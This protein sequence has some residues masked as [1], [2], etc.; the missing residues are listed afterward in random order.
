MTNKRA[1]KQW[2]KARNSHAYLS[3]HIQNKADRFSLSFYELIL[4]SNFKGG[5]ATICEPLDSLNNKLTAY[6]QILVKIHEKFSNIS[7]RD[8]DDN[9]PLNDLISLAMKFL[10]LTRCQKMKIDGFGPSY[11]STLLNAYFPELLPIIDKR[12][13]NG[14]KLKGAKIEMKISSAGQVENI[15]THYGE[16]I[17][18]IHEHLRNN[19]NTTILSIDK[20]LFSIDLSSGF[21][22]NRKVGRVSSNN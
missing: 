18:Y 7:L 12:A 9:Q 13:L 17:R 4:V 3:Q 2:T 15:E 14:A 1:E 22:R 16:L 10:K 20:Q 6:S 19:P 8:I 5:S 11:A 21:R